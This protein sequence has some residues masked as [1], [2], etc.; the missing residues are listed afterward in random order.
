[1]YL[2]GWMRWDLGFISRKRIST[3]Y[4]P[5]RK[6]PMLPTILCDAVC[7]LVEGNIRFAFTLD[8]RVNKETYEILETKLSNTVIR[9]KHNLRYKVKNEKQSSA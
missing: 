8:I 6:R 1:M 9:V 2:Y 5:D 7:S 3:I 4:L